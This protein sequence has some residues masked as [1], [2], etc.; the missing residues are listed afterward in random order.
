[1][2]S[3]LIHVSRVS[4]MGTMASTLAHELNQPLTAIAN[5][6]EAA[7]EL[8]DRRDEKNEAF[9]KEA[10]EEGAKEA[11]RAGQ[12]VRRLRDFVARGEV[13]QHVEN[14]PAMIEDASR[15][16]LAGARERGVR[17]FFKLDS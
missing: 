2:Q 13:A 11:L 10:V 5:Y 1:L 8:L 9:I 4:A 14:L 6:M 3:E 16:A 17:A 12:I 7:R 15:L